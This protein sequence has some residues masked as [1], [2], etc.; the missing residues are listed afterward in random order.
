M[1]TRALYSFEDE[2]GTFHVYKHHDGD[3]RGAAEAIVNALD[4]AWP[5]PR[6]EA[7]EFAAAF[8]AGNKP[9]W[10]A[11]IGGI[12]ELTEQ[13]ARKAAGGGVRMVMGDNWKEAAS[14]DIEFH[15]TITMV[16]D[17]LVVRADRVSYWEDREGRGLNA[18]DTTEQ[19]SGKLVAFTSWAATA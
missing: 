2:N 17:A 7:D 15:Y 10:R 13:E 19:F 14:G 5:L 4:H 11:K 12:A 1:S 8:V 6:F 3:P 18:W 9:H 16:N